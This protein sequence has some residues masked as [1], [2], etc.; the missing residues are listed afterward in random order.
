MGI[1]EADKEKMRE[2][3]KNYH[4][5][6]GEAIDS[7]ALSSP[8]QYNQK[9][10]KE[11]IEGIDNTIS[12]L[13]DELKNA[14]ITPIKNPIAGM[15]VDKDKIEK[16]S[17]NKAIKDFIMLLIAVLFALYISGFFRNHDRI[18]AG[19]SY[20]DEILYERILK[21]MYE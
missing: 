9:L 4:L 21:D 20:E 5:S 8:L 11:Q 17:L 3:L 18:P 1:T 10:T 19:L 6:R 14:P 15:I 2:N 13:A 7:V 16:A 12:K